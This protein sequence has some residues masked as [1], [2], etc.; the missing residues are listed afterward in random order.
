[1]SWI[2]SQLGGLLKVYARVAPTERGGYRLVKLA[3]RFMPDWRGRFSTPDHITLDLDLG[4]YPDC[5]MAFGLYELDTY[6]LLRRLLKPGMRFIDC[7]ANIGYFTLL[8]AKLVGSGGRV[9]AIEPDPLNRQRLIENVHRN[10]LADVVRVHA[11][12]VAAQPATVTLFHP[13]EDEGNHGQASL[14]STGGSAERFEVQA[15]RL[16][17]LIDDVPDVIKMDIEGAELDALRGATKLMQSP[18]PPKLIIEYN[19]ASAAA[20]GHTADELFRFVLDAQSKYHLDWIGSTLRR[21]ND[22]AQLA[23]FKRQGNVLVSTS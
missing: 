5:C 3:R 18:N 22:P 11:V 23:R 4:T 8:A 15:V 13:G 16:D 2:A 14:F 17:D 6:R 10:G 19:P 1:M 20:A 12:A 21:V 7:G 9:D